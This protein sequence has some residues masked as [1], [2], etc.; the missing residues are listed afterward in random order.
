LTICS[1]ADL[2]GALCC[3]A[4]G[5]GGAMTHAVATRAAAVK[6]RVERAGRCIWDISEKG[7]RH[8]V[9]ANGRRQVLAGTRHGI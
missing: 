9:K 3:A 5:D 2:S 1:T 8:D 4:A 6:M 7:F